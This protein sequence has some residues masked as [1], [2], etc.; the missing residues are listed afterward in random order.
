MH[1]HWTGEERRKGRPAEELRA[2]L[3]QILREW[4]AL[5]G[6]PTLGELE[7]PV[8]DRSSAHRGGARIAVGG[9]ARTS[10]PDRPP[11]DPDDEP[12]P[13]TPPDEPEPP[14]VK[15]PPPENPKGPYVV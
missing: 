1:A 2:Q 10:H 4:E 5:Q 8:D 6:R 12:P 13:T 3:R 14:P 15:D 11:R 9:S 7:D